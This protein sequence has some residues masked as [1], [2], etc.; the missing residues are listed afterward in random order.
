M[1]KN[2]SATM[3]RVCD[4]GLCYYGATV[5]NDCKDE[6]KL[7]EGYKEYLRNENGNRDEEE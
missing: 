7:E 4:E 2:M 6:K 3:C 5:C 1:G